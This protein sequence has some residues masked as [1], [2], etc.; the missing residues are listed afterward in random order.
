MNRASCAPFGG[1]CLTSWGVDKIQFDPDAPSIIYAAGAD[2]GI[3]RSWASDNGGAFTEVFFSMN[4]ANVGSDR[5]DIAMT[6]EGSLGD[7]AINAMVRNDTSGDLYVATDFTVL[8]RGARTG[9]WHTA[10]GGMP[11]VEVSSLAIDQS[12]RVIYAATHGRSAWRL[13]LK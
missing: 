12:K 3:Q 8:R 2:V 6:G 9:H 5:T 4:Q 10:A 1:A 13:A 7:L 11:M